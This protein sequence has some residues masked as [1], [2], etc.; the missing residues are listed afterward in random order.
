MVHDERQ[1]RRRKHNASKRFGRFRNS[2]GRLFAPSTKQT[3]QSTAK[4]AI[5][6]L[7]SRHLLAAQFFAPAEP[8][9]SVNVQLVPLSGV[10]TGT[11]EIVTFG[12]PFTRGSVS[13]SQ[14]AQVRV[15]KSGVEI[16]A[17]VEQLTPWRSIGDPAIDGQSVRVVRIQ[18]P[19]TFT[20]LNPETI[21]VQWG[22]PART[23]NRTTMQD[24]RIEWHSVTSGTLVAA[25]NVEEPDVLPVLPKEYLAKGMLDARTDPTA[26]GVTEP[27]DD[28]AMMDS[29]TFSGYTE[30]DYAEK[31]FFYTIINQNPDIN[32]DYK[33]QAEPWL[34]DRSSGMYELYLR[35]GFATAL[36]E[37][38][39]SADFYAHRRIWVLHAQAG[40]SE[41]LVQ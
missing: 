15:L 7:E 22:G 35:S 16:S 34:Y 24:P 12:V 36:R 5:E 25:D 27:R 28:P 3:V 33:T 37:A 11:Q 18:I 21:T 1:Q 26:Y 39:R 30:Y 6:Q 31:N 8:S 19:Y 40:R 2:F 20:T 23:L 32:I 13:Q 29:M 9:G 4:L 17:F 14:L 38:I 10:A 41:I